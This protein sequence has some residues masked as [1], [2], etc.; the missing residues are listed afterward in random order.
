MRIL[1]MVEIKMMIKNKEE[2]EEEA[3]KEQQQQYIILGIFMNQK[4]RW[5][6]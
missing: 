4:S 6:N 5:G 1:K 3:E 2:E